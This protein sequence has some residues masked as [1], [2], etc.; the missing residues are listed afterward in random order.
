MRY[1]LKDR[2]LEWCNTEITIG[3]DDIGRRTIGANDIAFVGGL[4]IY[5]CLKAAHHFA[6]SPNRGW[7][8]CLL[9]SYLDI[10]INGRY[11]NGSC[12]RVSTSF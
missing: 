8:R 10:K 7:V 4:P 5:Q 12:K 2:I 1:S 9:V 11:S 3:D 6:A